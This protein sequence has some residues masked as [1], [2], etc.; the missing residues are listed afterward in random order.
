[1]L[2]AL[3]LLPW[4]HEL[5]AWSQDTAQLSQRPLLSACYQ[6]VRV[7]G[8][9][10]VLLF[11]AL[12]A[13][14]CGLKR[15]AVA[16]IL[17]LALTAALVWPLKL[18][19]LRERPSGASRYS[20]PSGDTASA[21]AAAVPLVGRF[22]TAAPLALLVVGGVAAGRV[23]AGAHYPSDVAAGAAAG[24][25]AGALSVLAGRRFRLL[26]TWRHFLVATAVLVAAS[27]VVGVFSR[28]GDLSGEKLMFALITYGPFLSVLVAYRLYRPIRR[29]KGKHPPKRP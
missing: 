17:A 24:L 3:A 15:Q 27:A 14:I 20:F 10:D 16:M 28:R 13:G 19:V 21:A 2:A 7:V 12:V 6:I 8:K 29:R 11:F 9:T 4:D 18:G 22:P 23:L 5:S 1:M 25:V 26:L